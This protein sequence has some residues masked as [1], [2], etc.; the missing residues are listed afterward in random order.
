MTT[1]SMEKFWRTNWQIEFSGLESGRFHHPNIVSMWICSEQYRLRFYRKYF[2][3][4]FSAILVCLS[5]AFDATNANGINCV[6]YRNVNRMHHLCNQLNVIIN[7]TYSYL[8]FSIDFDI[9]RRI[10][11]IQT[12]IA[13]VLREYASCTVRSQI[14]GA[15]N[16]FLFV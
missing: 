1:E 15:I 16:D 6:V 8:H 4:V 9:R 12:I 14:E 11:F 5:H 10:R 3:A 2:N 7:K 13:L